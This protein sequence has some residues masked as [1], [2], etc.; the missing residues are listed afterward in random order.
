[1]L[2][3]IRTL[4]WLHIILGAFGLFGAMVVSL[5]GGSVAG[6]VH[7]VDPNVAVPGT[8]IGLVMAA[9]GVFIAL[10]SVPLVIAGW[11]LLNLRRWA[12]VLTL[13]LSAFNLFHVPFGTALAVYS[14]WVLLKPETDDVFRNLPAHA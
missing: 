5:I 2:T 4:G 10:I 6:L 8:I 14:F 3:H 7:I 1:M 12:R 9:A 13:V 11:G